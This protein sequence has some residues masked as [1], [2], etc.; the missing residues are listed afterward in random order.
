MSRSRHR[1]GPDGQTLVEFALVLPVFV[2]L[3]VGLF[4][5]G[6]AVFALSTINNA[7]REAARV[8][9]VDQTLAHVKAEGQAQAVALAIPADQVSVR[10][11][12]HDD[13]EDCSSQTAPSVGCIAVVTVEYTYVPATPVIGQLMGRITMRGTSFFPIEAECVE[14]PPPSQQCPQGD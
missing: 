10:Y 6:R 8:A 14:G 2:L 9:I 3:L 7:A 11:R 12:N 4:D 13:T 5:A 1:L